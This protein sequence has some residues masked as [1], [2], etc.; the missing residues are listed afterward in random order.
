MEQMTLWK[1]GKTTDSVANPIWEQLDKVAKMDTVTRLSLVMTKA[2]SL[3]R[4]A[5]PKKQETPHDE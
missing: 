5:A 3:D 4:N 2:V 1:L